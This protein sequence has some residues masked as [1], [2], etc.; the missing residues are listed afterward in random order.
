MT[1]YLADDKNN[2]VPKVETE[3]KPLITTEVTASEKNDTKA[4]KIIK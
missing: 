4:V 2:K 3:E 1:E